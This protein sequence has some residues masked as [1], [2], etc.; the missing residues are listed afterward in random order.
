MLGFWDASGAYELGGVKVMTG[1]KQGDTVGSGVS[2]H[3]LLV[4]EFV[5]DKKIIPFTR[6]VICLSGGSHE[7]AIF[8]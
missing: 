4:N 3:G 2:Q 6:T 5:V 8:I 1:G 7:E